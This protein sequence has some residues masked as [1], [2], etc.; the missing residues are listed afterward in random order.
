VVLRPALALISISSWQ[1]PG[2]RCSEPANFLANSGPEFF[3]ESTLLWI[4]RV[5]DL[6]TQLADTIVKSTERHNDDQHAIVPEH[7]R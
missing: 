1:V 7:P 3:K 5:Y 4:R 2:S 6:D